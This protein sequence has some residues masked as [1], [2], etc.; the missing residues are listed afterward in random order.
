MKTSMAPSRYETNHDIALLA[1]LGMGYK[2]IAKC[3]NM[4]V[5]TV[6][7]VVKRYRMGGSIHDAPRSG[8][9]TKQTLKLKQHIEATIDENPWASLRE[10][11]E[12]LKDLDI[13]QTTV[14]KVVKNDGFKL[15]IPR[16]SHLLMA[17][18]RS[19]GDTGANAR[20][21]GLQH[22]GKPWSVAWW[23]KGGIFWNLSTGEKGSI[24]DGEEVLEKHL[25]PSFQSGKIKVRCWAAISY[26]IRTPLVRVSKRKPSERKTG[27]DRLGLNSEHYTTKIYESH[28]ILFLFSLDKP[29]R[30]CSVLNDNALYY[31]AVVNR[32]VSSAYGIWKL[33]LPASSPDL[34][35]IEN[36]WHI[37]KQSLW[38]RFSKNVNE[39]PHSEDEL[40]AVMEEEWEAMNQAVIDRLIDSMPLR[41]QAIVKA[42]GS[43]IKW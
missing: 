3:K 18:W 25:V 10:I 32:Q 6:Q 24:H 12:T 36:V 5:S 27:H 40:W 22:A 7:G 17:S 2:K 11:T 34:N 43:Y 35:P 15:W 9:P 14:S 39:R 29:I 23:V 4:P 1:D 37:F 41:L 26:G 30:K 38:K 28:L 16:K 8:R 21:A 42:G 20:F 13:G 19:G 33:S 31:K